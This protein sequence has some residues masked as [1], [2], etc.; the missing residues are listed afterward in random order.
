MV[1]WRVVLKRCSSCGQ[2]VIESG[3]PIPKKKSEILKDMKVGDRVFCKDHQEYEG[4]RRTMYS[5]GM[6][7]KTKK[8]RKPDLAGHGFYIWRIE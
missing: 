7:Y 6:K 8:I 3:V 5:L 4:V 2:I 1:Q